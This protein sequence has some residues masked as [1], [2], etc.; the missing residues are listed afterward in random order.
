MKYSSYKKLAGC[1]PV[2]LHSSKFN[3]FSTGGKMGAE[4]DK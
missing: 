1:G 4:T 3:G 2:E